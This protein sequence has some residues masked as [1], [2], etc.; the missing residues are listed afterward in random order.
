MLR[1]RKPGSL[2]KSARADSGTKATDCSTHSGRRGFTVPVP[3]GVIPELRLW[4]QRRIM[5]EVGT[6]LMAG[7]QGPELARHV[8]EASCKLHRAEVPTERA[9]SMADELRI[10]HD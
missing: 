6:E 1:V 8:A 3:M 2:A 5:G 9:H 4:L 10:L 7:A